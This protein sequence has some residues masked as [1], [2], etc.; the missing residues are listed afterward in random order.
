MSIASRKRRMKYRSETRKTELAGK[1][2]HDRQVKAS[3]IGENKSKQLISI[4]QGIKS[5]K[6]IKAKQNS[7]KGQIR[8]CANL[9]KNAQA[10]NNVA[11]N[12]S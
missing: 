11:E 1:L 6:W 2:W 4:R 12:K 8:K 7:I 9:H 10:V 5:S 3:V